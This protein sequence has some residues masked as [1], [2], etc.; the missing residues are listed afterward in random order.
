MAINI[1]S[2][3]IKSQ[4]F[5]IGKKTYTV[6]YTSELDDQF[7]DMMLKIGKLLNDIQNTDYDEAMT[8][9]EQ[10]TLVRDAYSEMLKISKDYLIAALGQKAAD[11]IVRY[12]DNRTVTITKIAQA[13]FE[14]GQDNDLKQKYGTNR[15]ERRGKGNN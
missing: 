1:T 10:R 14:A 13:I 9:D 8:L 3:V 12:A 2:L 6:R 4:D 15:K 11:E 7:S 5:T